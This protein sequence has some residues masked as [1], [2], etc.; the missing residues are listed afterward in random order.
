M[1]SLF[2]FKAEGTITPQYVQGFRLTT[3]VIFPDR[4]K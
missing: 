1:K 2:L 4:V 3:R